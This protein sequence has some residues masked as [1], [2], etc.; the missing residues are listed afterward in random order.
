MRETKRPMRIRQNG[1]RITPTC[2]Q[3]HTLLV[4]SKMSTISQWLDKWKKEREDEVTKQNAA[5]KGKALFAILRDTG[6]SNI[7]IQIVGPANAPSIDSV[8]ATNDLRAAWNI[9]TGVALVDTALEPLTM[10]V[11]MPK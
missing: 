7:R 2:D 1:Q 3:I 9:K 11:S 8:K 4:W 6:F 5:E 10:Q